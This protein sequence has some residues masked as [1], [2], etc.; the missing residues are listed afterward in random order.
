VDLALSALPLG[1]TADINPQSLHA[2]ET[3]VLTLTTK[4]A[5]LGE[6]MLTIRGTSGT[7]THERSFTAAVVEQVVETML[8]LI[9][10]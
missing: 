10:K 8:P 3:A 1:V 7:L 5:P 6:T 2:G 9:T 4:N